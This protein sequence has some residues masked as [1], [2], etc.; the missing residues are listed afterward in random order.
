MLRRRCQAPWCSCKAIWVVD[1]E[2]VYCQ[3]HVEELDTA[4]YQKVELIEQAGEQRIEAD[5][6]RFDALTCSGVNPERR[7]REY[8]TEVL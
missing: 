4:P 3:T 2:D 7:E 8:G 5:C 1:D 6:V